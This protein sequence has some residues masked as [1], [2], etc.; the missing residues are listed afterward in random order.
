MLV[1][2]VL[3]ALMAPIVLEAPAPLCQAPAPALQASTALLAALLQLVLHALP[4]AIALVALLSLSP[5]PHSVASTALHPLQVL[6]V[7]L[8]ATALEAL[9]S[10]SPAP[11]LLATS[12]QPLLQA[13]PALALLA[14]PVALA[15]PLL[16]AWPALLAP[17]ALE[18]LLLPSHPT[19]ATP[20][21]T[22]LEQTCQPA[23]QAVP[24]LGQALGSA[25][26][27]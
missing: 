7:L 9:L 19:G 14:P 17:H 8:T 1:P 24:F 2:P 23:L 4:T 27:P 13:L 5:V 26:A 16:Q 22:S 3:P 21:Q 25:Q 20:M 10:L 6:L 11:L 12:A 18:A 15:A